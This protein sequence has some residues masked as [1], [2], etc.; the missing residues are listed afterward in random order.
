MTAGA[1]ILLA[2]LIVAVVMAFWRQILA[3]VAAAILLAL[4]V[5]VIELAEIFKSLS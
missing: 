1:E 5:G 4:V 2:C 3:L